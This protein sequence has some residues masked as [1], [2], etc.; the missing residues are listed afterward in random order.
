MSGDGEK[1]RAA[2]CDAYFSKPF[3]SRQLL[4]KVRKYLA[5]SAI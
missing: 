3:S 5:A 1:A 2:G 4:A